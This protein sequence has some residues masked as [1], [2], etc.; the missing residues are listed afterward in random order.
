MLAL[1]EGVCSEEKS[2]VQE[3]R[4]KTPGLWQKIKVR[5]TQGQEEAT[6]KKTDQK[7]SRDQQPSLLETAESRVAGNRSSTSPH[8]RLWTRQGLQKQTRQKQNLSIETWKQT[9]WGV[10][11]CAFLSPSLGEKR[12]PLLRDALLPNLLPSFCLLIN[13]TL[14]FQRL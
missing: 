12:V 11:P 7:K 10:S 9:L 8:T 14:T 4:W 6:V 2:T 13:I 5:T 3:Q 1:K